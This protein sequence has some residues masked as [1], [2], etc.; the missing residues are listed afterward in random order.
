MR[1][2]ASPA[3]SRQP[4]GTRR[5]G[6]EAG[7]LLGALFTGRGAEVELSCLLAGSGLGLCQF[8]LLAAATV[9]DLLPFPSWHSVDPG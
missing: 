6:S 2:E 7:S 1:D 4:V 3:L 9:W 8:S 5:V